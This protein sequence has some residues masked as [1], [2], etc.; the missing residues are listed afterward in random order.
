MSNTQLK[1]LRHT[2]PNGQCENS[3]RLSHNRGVKLII[4]SIFTCLWILDRREAWMDDGKM[5]MIDSW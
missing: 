4:T 1:L 2:F 3:K 5:E